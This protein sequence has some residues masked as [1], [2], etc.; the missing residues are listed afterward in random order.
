MIWPTLLRVAGTGLNFGR[1]SP[2]VV[3]K[4]SS[5]QGKLVQP[6]IM[7]F[8]NDLRLAGNAALAASVATGQPVI[9]LYVLDDESSGSWRMGAA[10][11]WWL[12]K[13]LASLAQSLH[14]RGAALILRSG[15]ARVVLPKL[16]KET[17]ASAIYFSRAYEP[18]AQRL[19]ADLKRDMDTTGVSLHRFGGALLTEPEDVLTK[20]GEPFKVYSPFWRALSA[21][22]YPGNSSA[23]PTH[24]T[25]PAKLPKSEALASWRLHPSKP[26]W[27]GGMEQS[28]TPGEAAAHARLQTFVKTSI[29]DY[30]DHR[31]RPDIDGTSRLS[32]HLHFGEITPRQCWRTAETAAS[33]AKGSVNG[34]ETFF[35]EIAWRDFSYTL[36]VQRPD[37]P[38]APFRP[39]FA[40]FPWR[41][42]EVALK[43]WQRGRTGF[44]IVDAGMRE[45]W[46]TGYMHNRVRMITAS[47]LIKDLLIPWQTGQA[48]FWDTLV[49]AD[50]AS[51]SASWQW[52]AG[53]G[54]DAAP[55]FRIF[56]P[57]TQG[58]K[59]DPDGL[60]I[61]R[62]V[63]ELA[64]LPTE[65]IHAP[66]LAPPDILSSAGIKL[67]KTY[68]TPIVDHAAAR[69]RALDALAR[70]KKSTQAA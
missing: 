18:W 59:F 2:I 60:Y 27:S 1:A 38:E 65:H 7:W 46:A 10:S 32:P 33:H 47:F 31:N 26:V 57:T 49:D 51:N 40:S 13:S 64:Q 68:P 39:E 6:V 53:S 62:W 70:I 37:L 48:W 50:L 3:S 20:S 8:R 17:S 28:W 11:R 42:D 61:R 67:G 16:I 29:K 25:A 5:P 45:L 56:N 9:A 66:W 34:L 23:A 4:I 36:L 52:V 19:E 44:P 69:A 43:A 14:T 58:V 21:D 12:N 22:F 54:A 41:D 15:N 63:P 30:A 35:K 24:I 55:Y